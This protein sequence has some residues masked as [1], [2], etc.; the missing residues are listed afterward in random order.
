M[1][2]RW[3]HRVVSNLIPSQSN[4]IASY[5][6][7]GRRIRIRSSL[8]SCTSAAQL[9][10]VAAI[11]WL[12]FS[13]SC[14][15]RVVDHTCH[16]RHASETVLRRLHILEE[17]LEGKM[18]TLKVEQ[19][20][21]VAAFDIHRAYYSCS[22]WCWVRWVASFIDGVCFIMLSFPD[23]VRFAMAFVS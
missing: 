23:G 8:A 17:V 3:P 21:V 11:A 10:V 6:S 19:V 7:V 18:T 5:C 9:M 4:T 14:W 16:G 1:E 13:G 2:Q 15:S 12:R 20:V 22:G